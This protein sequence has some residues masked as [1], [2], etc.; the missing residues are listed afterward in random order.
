MTVEKEKQKSFRGVA[1]VDTCALVGMQS[2]HVQTYSTLNEV[3]RHV[4]R[5][6]IGLDDWILKEQAHLLHRVRT[7]HLLEG[8]REG[9]ERE[10]GAGQERER[11]REKRR[12]QRS[13]SLF[14]FL[15]L[16]PFPLFPSWE[17][18]KGQSRE[19]DTE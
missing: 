8:G 15:T 13:T 1:S 4:V 19:G 17:V 5:G 10:E 7:S 2:V 16:S 3:Q 18:V 11:D 9:G 12:Y 14:I 6:S